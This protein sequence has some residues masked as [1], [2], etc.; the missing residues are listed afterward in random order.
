MKESEVS[1]G[2]EQVP[3]QNWRQIFRYENSVVVHNG[4]V[5]EAGEVHVTN[6]EHMTNDDVKAGRHHPWI[7]IDWGQGRLIPDKPHSA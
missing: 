6:V 3:E 5:D 4:F 7:M 1:P 2:L